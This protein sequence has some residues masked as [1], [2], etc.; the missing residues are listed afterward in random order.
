MSLLRAPRVDR[1][2]L[3]MKAVRAIPLVLAAVAPG[4]APA[5]AAEPRPGE[6]DPAEVVQTVPSMP[7]RGATMEA[8]R[9]RLGR[10]RART[11]PVGDPPITRWVYDE[12][13]VYFEHDR[14]IHSVKRRDR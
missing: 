10:P 1:W 4:M 2:T 12:F 8:V 11:D 9:D 5:G 6:I 14:V 3:N 13:T 7:P